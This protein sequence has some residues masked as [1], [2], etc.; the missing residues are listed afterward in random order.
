MLPRINF[1]MTCVATFRQPGAPAHHL[2]GD[3][4]RGLQEVDAEGA[5]TEREV[6]YDPE[7]GGERH[8]DHPQADGAVSDEAGW[9]E[10]RVRHLYAYDARDGTLAE[11]GECGQSV[12]RL[13]I[14]L[15]PFWSSV[16]ING[17]MHGFCS[18]FHQ[19]S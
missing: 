14:L 11:Q 6:D 8:R 4:D 2:H 7:Q 13:V 1:H 17:E 10:E 18:I 12:C 3:G 15:F 9:P 19:C 5:G 16:N